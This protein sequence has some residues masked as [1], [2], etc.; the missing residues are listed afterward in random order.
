MRRRASLRVGAV[1]VGALWT[2]V[3]IE[4]ESFAVQVS[5]PKKGAVVKPGEAMKVKV[6]FQ[7]GLPVVKVTYTLF[8]EDRALDDIKVEA[9]P[10]VE[11]TAAPFDAAISVPVEAVGA[12]RLLA[13]AQV[14]ERRGQYVL[15]DEVSFRAE[16]AAELKGLEAEIPVR[17]T[18]TIGEVRLLSVRGRYAD[19]VA[20]DLTHSR[21]GTTY[22]SS[23]EKIVRVNHDGLAQAM[24]PGTAEIMAKNGKQ[25]VKIPVVVEVENPE[26]RPPVAHAG[27]DQTVKQGA[28]V[29]L[30]A[31]LSG[32]PEGK[33]PLYYW[34][35]VQGMP[36]NLVEPLSPRPYFFAPV[37]DE[38]RVLRFR[39]IV[40]DE[41]G[42]ESFPAY[43]NVTVAP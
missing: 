19:R 41:E 15:F 30:D 24:G 14:A 31:L 7:P 36:I 3:G 21:T 27:T 2:L 22:R 20:R 9:P 39:L 34:S 38:P 10:M 12:M 8:E 11:A 16:P 26:N 13:V 40:R 35:Q 33:N 43:V 18:K 29:R 5:E 37:V 28:R 23:D 42:A 6:R 25:E 4:S 32:D 1:L 17:F